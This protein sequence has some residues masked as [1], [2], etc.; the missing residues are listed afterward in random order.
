MM[1]AILQSSNAQFSFGMGGQGIRI[2]DYVLG[3]NLDAIISQLADQFNGYANALTIL[4][5]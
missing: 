3:D 4:I 1:D 5:I 2:G